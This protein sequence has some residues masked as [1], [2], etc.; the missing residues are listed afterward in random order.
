M[1][2]FFGLKK[3]V[4]L[5]SLVA[6]W[7]ITPLASADEMNVDSALKLLLED[8][9]I[10]RYLR[11]R[12]VDQ[13]KSGSYRVQVGDTLDEI[14]ELIMSESGVKKS[15]IRQAFVQANP[16]AFRSENPNWLIAGREIRVPTADD[17]LALIFV[18]PP[19]SINESTKN[20]VKYP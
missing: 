1:K 6:A 14:I 18:T 5:C 16:S 3:H 10:Q 20:W 17:V 12:Q 13:L 7:A 8:V 11:E 4:L 15:F 2:I 19:K 9:E